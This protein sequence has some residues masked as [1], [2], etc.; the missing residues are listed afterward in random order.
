MPKAGFLTAIAGF[1]C[2]VPI[3]IHTFTGQT[4]AARVGFPRH[5]YYLLDRLINSLNTAC[6]TD[7][8]SQSAFLQENKITN[9][10]QLLPVL[11][12][13]SLSGVDITR[14]NLLNLTESANE[15]RTSLG[16]GKDN[17]VFAFIAR[18]TRDK[19]AFDVL[20]AFSFVAS[21]FKDARLLF[22]GPDE[23]GEIALL[24][25]K[26]PELFVHVINVDHVSNPEVYLAITDVLCLPSYREGFGSIVIDA[27]AM[28]V[29]T[30]G[31]RIPGLTDSVV[32][33][34]TGALFPAGNVDDMVKLMLNF[35]EKPEMRLAMG[36]CAKARVDEY[37]TAD[38]LY[39][40]LKEF[41][42]T[43]AT[44]NPIVRKRLW[45]LS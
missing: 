10:G 29:P 14:F 8:F 38:C 6:L 7:S 19:G 3:R 12:K 15:L 22:V 4:W 17:F 21:V 43:C 2:R 1:V 23:D 36:S 9:S 24:K 13:G 45:N 18:K 35:I 40:A 26:N 34:K 11:S 31:S 20:K 16:V 27:A 5:F 25:K 44:D 33:Q 30:I 39:S 41:Y 28:S 42:V 37:F 32:D